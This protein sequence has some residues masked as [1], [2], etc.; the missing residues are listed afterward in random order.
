MKPN[1]KVNDPHG[2]QTPFRKKALDLWQCGK[3]ADLKEHCKEDIQF[4]ELLMS[5]TRVI[6][7]MVA[8]KVMS[9]Q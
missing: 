4:Y 6:D 1:E 8:R 9:N 5:Y 7:K 3:Y 2:K